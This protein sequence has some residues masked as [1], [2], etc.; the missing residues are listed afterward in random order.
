MKLSPKELEREKIEFIILLENIIARPLVY[1]DRFDELFKA[2]NAYHANQQTIEDLKSERDIWM[3]AATILAR[4]RDQSNRKL[5][6]H[7]RQIA[8][9]EMIPLVV[10]CD[11]Y[12]SLTK[13]HQPDIQQFAIERQKETEGL[14]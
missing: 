5:A 1:S 3:E 9:G 12:G 10:V 11:W 13:D 14:V 6:E 7:E 4:N 8:G 2:A